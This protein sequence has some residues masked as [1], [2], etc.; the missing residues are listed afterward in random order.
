[1]LTSGVFLLILAVGWT[2]GFRMLEQMEYAS[3][4]MK[5]AIIAGLLLGLAVYFWGTAGDGGL[6]FNPPQ[7]IGWQAVTLAFGLIVTVQGFET[8]RYLGA[9]YDSETRIRSMRL[10]QW[11]SSAIYLV[12]ICL[13]A[14]V[15][16]RGEIRFSET[17]IVDMMAV[18]AP[19]LPFLLVAAALA[20][21]FS[22]AVADTSGSGGLFAELTKN[23]VSARQAYFGLT[24]VGL[25]LTWSADIFQIISYAS[26]AFAFYY[27]L[28][29]AIASRAA[30]RLPGGW[31]RSV[32]FAA[33]AVTGMLIVLFGQP[34]ENS[35]H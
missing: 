26:R 14:F 28:Q 21:Q 16:K 13:I 9:E 19:V 20:A 29:A 12:Y 33:M 18:V 25:A 7:Q 5:L 15:F 22:A 6:I 31:M 3:V 11:V 30:C 32:L 2:R 10:A 1:L 27:A 17:G 23:R 4:T 34:V 24:V 35:S 8:S